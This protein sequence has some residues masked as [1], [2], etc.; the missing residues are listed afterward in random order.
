MNHFLNILFVCISLLMI[1]RNMVREFIDSLALKSVFELSNCLN[2]AHH[3][4]FSQIWISNP[5]K[6]EKELFSQ[7]SFATKLKIY[8]RLD[9]GSKQ[10]K[11]E[12]IIPILRKKRRDVPIIAVTC[13]TADITAWAA[14]DNRV[15]ILKFPIFHTKLLTRSVAKLMIK[16]EK[17]FE[18]PLSELYSLPNNQQIPAVRQI[19]TA[20]A[21]TIQK[22][23]PI[24]LSSSSSRIEEIRAPRDLAA[25][26]E[27]LF[28]T[29]RLALDSI[30]TNP[31]QLLR[32]NLLKTQPE[33]IMPGVYRVTTSS[34][35][36]EN[37]EE[38][39]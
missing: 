4:G 7:S 19:R 9:I 36:F 28:K 39:E 25:L 13:L 35:I 26:G 11:K 23:V 37:S 24:I 12:Q 2:L 27:I 15:D 33:Y 30:S 38:E 32:K 22:K 20:V 8:E 6:K 1:V 10:E 16:F 17:Y 21:I 14:Q 18:I 29:P 31:Q 3:L 5:T 34:S